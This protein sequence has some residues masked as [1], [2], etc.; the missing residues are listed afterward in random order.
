M[1]ITVTL[2]PA[3]D[4]TVEIPDFSLDAVNRITTI[5]TDPGGKGLNVSKVIAKLGGK[6]TAVGVLGG[7]TGRRI[8]DA[9]D[10][11]GIAC[12]F[13]FVEGETRTNLKVIDPARHTN[14][15]LNEPGLT[16]TQDTLDGMLHAVTAAVQPGDIVVLSGSL[17]KAHRRILTACGPPPAAKRARASFWMRT[18]S[19]W[20]TALRPSP[21]LPSPTITSCPA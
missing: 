21:I 5:R 11:L 14:T 9:M 6:S 16:V 17:P 20:R 3:L 13:T 4:K 1:I 15:D 2:N 19:R 8:A 7:A 10:A 18:A 12:N